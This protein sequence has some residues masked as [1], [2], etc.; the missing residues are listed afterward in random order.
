MTDTKTRKTFYTPKTDEEFQ[1]LQRKFFAV[2]FANPQDPEIQEVWQ[3][4]QKP[5]NLSIKANE[6]EESLSPP[7]D[8]SR[9]KKINVPVL[10]IS[11]EKS[12]WFKPVDGARVASNYPMGTHVVM[13]NA[14]MMPWFDD[15]AEFQKT[16]RDFLAKYPYKKK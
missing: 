14:A 16:V 6:A 15:P 9:E 1:A 4:C 11:G 12:E 13:K 10:V 8:V 5:A 7:W 3:R 2:Q